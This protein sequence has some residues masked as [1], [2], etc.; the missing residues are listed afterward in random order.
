M[1]RTLIIASAVLLVAGCGSD[2]GDQ[3]QTIETTTTAPPEEEEDS[4]TTSEASGDVVLSDVVVQLEDLP[5]GWSVSPPDDQADDSDDEFCEGVDPFNEIPPQDEAESSFQQSDFGPFIGSGAAHYTDE[6]EASE[7]ID[8]VSET[9]NACQS[10]TET[11]EDGTETEYTI[12]PLSFPDL[13]D[14]TF[15]F[16][17]SASSLFG[18][19]ALDVAAVR[20]GEFTVSIIAG[21]FGAPPDSELTEELAQTMLDRL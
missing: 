1:R 8:L 19:F 3:A 13:G 10:F 6:D 5:S 14:E 4:T 20:D 17:V 2:D 9:A 21:G 15:A 12:A 7:V 18:P 16:R 11:D